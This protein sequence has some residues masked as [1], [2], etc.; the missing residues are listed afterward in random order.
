MG[1]QDCGLEQPA[2]DQLDLQALHRVR[3]R[4]VSQRTGIMN[5][6]RART[7]VRSD[8]MVHEIEDPAADCRWLDERA[9]AGQ[10]ARWSCDNNCV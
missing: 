1:R 3:E 9:T 8:R 5:Q 10:S 4:L 6:I 2:A 7:D